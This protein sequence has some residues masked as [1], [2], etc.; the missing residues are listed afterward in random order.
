MINGLI[1]E[2]QPGKQSIWWRDIVKMCFDSPSGEW[3]SNAVVRKLGDGNT[4]RFWLDTWIGN[5]PLAVRFDRL[6]QL[7][8]QKQSVLA[9]MG[10]WQN[11]IWRWSLSWR[12]D[13]REWELSWLALLMRTVGINFFL[14]ANA[15][16]L[17]GT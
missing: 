11:G 7:S 1:G 12:R 3:F 5:A 6:Y 14:L 2:I 15:P 4:V 17:F 13:L 10:S 16:R 8:S 9:D